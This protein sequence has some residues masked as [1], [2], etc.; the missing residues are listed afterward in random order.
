[1]TLMSVARKIVPRVLHQPV[2]RVCHAV[3]DRVDEVLGRADLRPPRRL[4]YTGSGSFTGIGNEFL[5]YFIEIAGLR[6]D[7][8]VLDVGSGIGRMAIPLTRYL[9]EGEYEGFDIVPTGVAWCQ[10]HITPR[11]PNFRFQL[12]D[13][14]NT[15]YNPTGR[16]RGNDYRFPY[17]DDSFDFVF[18]TS[19][20]TH[21]LPDEVENYLKEIARVSR[22]GGR[23]L[24]TFFL[25]NEE[26]LALRPRLIDADFA[27]DFGDYRVVDP[28]DPASAIA[29]RESFVR[30]RISRFGLR[31]S[32]PIHYGSWCGRREFTSFQDLLLVELPA[33]SA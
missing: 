33:P 9:R 20:F 30:E 21:L 32:E 19:V 26:S 24:M 25:L 13:I 5:R 27:Y 15:H 8:R 2:R 29:F 11:F 22:P 4:V 23:C 12:A 14:H 3:L 1:M 16:F 7:E 10:E 28:E 18:L 6:S 17:D 31:L